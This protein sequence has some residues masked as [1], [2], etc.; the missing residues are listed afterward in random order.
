MSVG[1]S[2][3]EMTMA[4]YESAMTLWEKTEGIGLSQADSRENIGRF[5]SRNP[6]LSFVAIEDG[7]LVGAVMS[8][9][10]GRRGFL[11]HLAVAPEQR[12]RGTGRL[13]V[14]A[15]LKELAKQGMQKCHIFV[16]AD[17]ESG[18]RFWRGTGWY[19]RFDLTAMSHDL[20]A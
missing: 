7:T 8:G 17:N 15:C 20:G 4:D 1:I 6:G 19:E 16:L 18:K 12:R 5:L 13:L 3:R 14:E 11:Y 10:D 9:H 2:I